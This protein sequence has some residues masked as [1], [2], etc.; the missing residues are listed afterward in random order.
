MCAMDFFKIGLTMKYL[1]YFVCV[2]WWNEETRR[3]LLN[4]F[5]SL[6]FKCS[7]VR[8][9]LTVLNSRSSS[10]FFFSCFCSVSETLNLSVY[11]GCWL[12][13]RVG[14]HQI[15]ITKTNHEKQLCAHEQKSID[16]MNWLHWK[17]WGHEKGNVSLQFFFLKFVQM[18]NFCLLQ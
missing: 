8:L 13:N 2:E 12:W 5:F 4:D 15:S 11:I 9:H 6:L 17:E 7:F 3:I 18:K 16:Y 14:F 1:Y 10:K